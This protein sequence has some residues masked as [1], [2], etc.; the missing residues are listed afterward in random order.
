M[1]EFE[2]A[3]AEQMRIA[4]GRPVPTAQVQAKVKQ[5]NAQ[6]KA[7]GLKEWV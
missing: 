7:L 6:R 1:T 5:W 2:K 4:Q 3:T